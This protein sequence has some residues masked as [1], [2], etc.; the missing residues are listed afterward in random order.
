MNTEQDRADFEAWYQHHHGDRDVYVLDESGE[1]ADKQVQG[2]FN[3]WQAAIAHDR[4]DHLRTAAEMMPSDAEILELWTGDPTHSRPVMGKS[5]VVAF[6]RALLS[7]Y[8]SSQSTVCQE[9]GGDGAG[10]LHE[11]DCSQNSS[12][13]TASCDCDDKS[14]CWEPCGDLGHGA[15]HAKLSSGR[16]AASAE[17]DLIREA[18]EVAR[19]GLEWYR[20]RCPD[21]VDGSDDEADELIGCALA[22]L[23][24]APVAQEPVAFL[25]RECDEE[26]WSTYVV[27]PHEM[28]ST[29]EF[30]HVEPLFA[31]HVLAQAQHDDA[32]ITEAQPEQMPASVGEALESAKWRNALVGLC[33]TDRI[34]TP[35]QAVANVKRRMRRMGAPAQPSAQDR[36]D[37]L[38]PAARDVLSERQRQ[39][40][41]EGWTP[42]HDDTHSNGSLGMAAACYCEPRYRFYAEP[43]APWPWDKKWWKPS[44]RRRDLIKA[45]ALILA[46]IERIDRAAARAAK[47]VSHG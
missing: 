17:P 6:A 18:L 45:G 14:Q 20:D 36:E 9:C 12:G 34:N 43:P 47:G 29:G 27:M 19:N 11:D 26:G 38:S 31:A 37:A 8:S 40:N 1:Y 46:E 32:A 3:V 44:D 22:S 2:A 24:A 7:R 4:Q 21:A 15:E 28:P 30:L 13:Q 25:C 23:D 41:A 5:K 10:G 16:P 39:I 35:E 33:D 42:E